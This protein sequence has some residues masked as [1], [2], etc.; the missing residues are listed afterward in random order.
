MKSIGAL[1]RDV[2]EILV[3][4]L[5]IAIVIR[6]FIIEVTRVPTP[7]MVPSIEAGDR[8]LTDKLWFH[9][10]GL[11]HGDVVVFQPPFATTEP[12]V[13]R[14]IGLPGDRIAVRDGAVY[15]NGQPL[16]E[17]YLAEKP[18][19]TRAEVTVPPGKMLVLGD[20]RNYSN[21]SSRWEGNGIQSWGFADIKKVTG[22][23]I[24]RLFPLNQ[25]GP[26]AR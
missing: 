2:I 21:D 14:I 23:V 5:L 24:W 11:R 16:N 1:L 25:F 17:P 15:R 20:N 3:A 19:Y 22:R 18:N 26:M 12:Y 7:S 8:L 10:S 6:T 13:K 9:I 4:A